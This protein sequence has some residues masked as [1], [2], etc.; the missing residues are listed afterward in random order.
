MGW[1]E[2]IGA[3]IM[4]IIRYLPRY[5]KH[6]RAEF[7]ED[8]LFKTVIWYEQ[9]SKAELEK[10]P[11]RV[12]EKVPERVTE[13][14]HKIIE[15]IIK[16]PHIVVFELPKIIGISERKVKENISK[17]KAKGI[18]RRV[19]PDKGGHWEIIRKK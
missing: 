4:N 5:S 17:L 16:K 3:G 18:I 1:A 6:G 15:S 13:N 11:E 7:T 12:T 8:E 2:E 9:I 19:G 10:V 14:Q